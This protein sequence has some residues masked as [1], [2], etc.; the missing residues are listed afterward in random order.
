MD[1]MLYKNSFG[2]KKPIGFLTH[3]IPNELVELE[4]SIEKDLKIFYLKEGDGV[5]KPTATLK[6]NIPKGKWKISYPNNKA[7]VKL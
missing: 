5:N 4:V 7:I 3:L 2:S 1:L 6:F